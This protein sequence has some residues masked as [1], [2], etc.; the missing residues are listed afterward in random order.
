MYFIVTG[1]WFASN[2]KIL[3]FDVDAAEIN[4]NIQTDACVVGDALEVLKRVNAKIGTA[5]QHHEW[6]EHIHELMR[7]STRWR[8]QKRLS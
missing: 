3:H 4:K 2:A 1:L 6:L 7:N 8:Y 5:G